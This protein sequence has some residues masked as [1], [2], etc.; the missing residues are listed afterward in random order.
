[1]AKLEFAVPEAFPFST[2]IALL[3]SHINAGNHLGNDALGGLL[4]EAHYGEVLRFDVAA[5]DFHRCGFDIAYRV[6]DVSS[7]RAV[8]VAKTAHLVV[9]PELGRAVDAPAE[10]VAALK[11]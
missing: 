5:S 7:G 11:G 9:S 10:M 6:S 3:R 8:A 4:S 2:D 1:M